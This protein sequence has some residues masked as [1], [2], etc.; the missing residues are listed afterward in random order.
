MEGFFATLA[1]KIKN[2]A[3]KS[4][5]RLNTINRTHYLKKSEEMTQEIAKSLKFPEHQL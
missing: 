4:I 3:K 1:A 5:I 2:N